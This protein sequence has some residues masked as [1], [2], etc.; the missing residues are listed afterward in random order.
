MSNSEEENVKQSLVQFM[1]KLAAG[2]KP[3]D[4]DWGWNMSSDP[5]NDKWL[6]VT[7]D[8]RLQHVKKIVLD[9]F[10]FTGEL[11]ARSV[12][13]A[14]SLAV[15]NLKGNNI[16]GLMPEEIG[17][18]KYLT[19]LYVSGNQFFGDMPDSFAQLGNLKKLDISNN[20]FSGKLPDL[21]Q[22]SGLVS[23]FAQNNQFSGAI[24]DFEFSNFQEFNV[25]NNNFS[26][27]IPDVKGKFAADSFLGNPDL[28]GKPLLNACPPSAPL[29]GMG[30]EH[31][32]KDQFLIYS[33]YIILG[34][35]LVL[36]LALKF[37]GKKRPTKEKINVVN[38]SVAA[39]NC[40]EP[41]AT[42]SEFK[43]GGNR[44]E[45]SITSVE[46]GMT[47]SS[48]VVLTSPLVKGL[49]FEDLLQAPAELL[50]RGKH[51]SLYKV[52]LND[53]MMLVVK[54]IKD[55]GISSEDFKRRMQRIDQVKHPGVLPVVAFYCSKQEKL[56]VYEC[57]PN[58]S[59][60]KLLH[61]KSGLSACILKFY[62]T[63]LFRQKGIL[64]ITNDT[65]KRTREYK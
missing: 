65:V 3:N 13:M 47:S 39:N 46:G 44:S 41:S 59:L 58:G 31:S 42:S 57:Q 64:R 35:V 15:L 26:G 54:R 40:S 50:G 63:S 34:L 28:C 53:G 52:I 48:L 36:L 8:S 14:N 2:N 5:C 9:K 1:V 60:F 25:S 21:F 24:P 16:I 62:F 27:P 20:K 38:K 11:D 61:G 19:H 4:R 6:G 45:Y 17:H 49:K 32:S 33:G 43:T 56:L 29:S 55:W 51:G 30:K 7:C 37:L 10:N 18:C 23:F 22:I 12:C